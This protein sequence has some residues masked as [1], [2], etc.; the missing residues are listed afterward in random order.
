MSAC[1]Y[2]A[3]APP[4]HKYK[5]KR[6][7]KIKLNEFLVHL[8]LYYLSLLLIK[9]Q[10]WLENKISTVHVNWSNDPKLFVL[11]SPCPLNS[12]WLH[13][14]K[15]HVDL[16]LTDDPTPACPDFGDQYQLPIRDHARTLHQKSPPMSLRRRHPSPLD[17]PSRILAG[18]QPSLSPRRPPPAA[19]GQRR[20]PATTST[21][22]AATEIEAAAERRARDRGCP[23][24]QLSLGGR[25]RVDTAAPELEA[26]VFPTAG[27]AAVTL[28]RSSDG[29][30]GLAV[31][32]RYTHLNNPLVILVS[33]Q[34]NGWFFSNLY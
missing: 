13:V 17:L 33:P 28:A 15:N 29:G 34:L 32:E 19:R 26:M 6:R 21:L 4:A 10:T 11:P 8:Y 16:N 3:A 20:S 2:Q 22:P 23:P 1:M 24:R 7:E 25:P 31:L 27:E 18:S 14:K 5:T 12:R 30:C 9:A